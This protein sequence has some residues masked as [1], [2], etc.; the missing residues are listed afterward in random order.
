VRLAG[1]APV[2]LWHADRD[3]A[4][5]DAVILPGGFSYGDYLRCGAIA[6]FGLDELAAVHTRTLP[7]LFG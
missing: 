5:V 2:A 7:A 3:L 6:R 4:G 1:G